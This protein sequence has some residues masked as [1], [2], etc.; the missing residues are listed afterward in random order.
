[1]KLVDALELISP[2]LPSGTLQERR[3]RS[4]HT[5]DDLRRAAKRLLPRSVFDYVDGGADQELSLA[6]NPTAFTGYRYHPKVMRDV[7]NPN[8]TGSFFG[9]TAALPLGLAPT[10][11]TRMMHPEGEPAVGRAANTQRIPYVLS[12]MASTSIE[13]LATAVGPDS[14]LWFQLYVWKDRELTRQMIHRAHASGYRVLEIAVDTAVSGNRVRDR[15]NGLT[16]PPALTLGSLLDIGMK[17]NYWMRMLRGEKLEFANVR[18]DGPG[19]GHTIAG[20]SEQFD[21]SVNWDDLAWIREAWVGPMVLKGPL[22]PEDALRA[23][24]LGIDGVHLSNH[25]GRQLDRTVAPV[26]LIAPVRAAVGDGFGVFVDSGIRH[27]SDIATAIALGADAAFVGRPYLWA[28]VA[29]GEDGVEHLVNTLAAEFTRT[30]QLLGVGSV[31]ELRAHGPEL[32]SALS[33]AT[34]ALL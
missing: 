17:P 11:Y 12:T 1:M 23:K 14:D 3:L 28:L 21:P 18:S 9:R 33:P 29:G 2:R 34:A 16:I 15:R 27:G 4:C 5:V 26:E 7:S 19:G 13:D 22:G 20:I 6:A 10:G 30:L 31:D 25:G 32:L 24:S 8:I